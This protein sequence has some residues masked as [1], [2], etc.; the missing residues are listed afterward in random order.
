M[1]RAVKSSRSVRGMGLRALPLVVGMVAMLAAAQCPGART[2]SDAKRPAAARGDSAEQVVYG[3]RMLLTQQNVS[4]G[5]LTATT[6][7]VFAEGTRLELQGVVF[8]FY[9]TAGVK[10]GVL[11]GETGTY[12]TKTGQLNVRGKASV[13]RQ[14]GRRLESE[15]IL[16]DHARS[17]ISADGAFV[18]SDGPG[19]PRVSGTTFES[20]ARLR[21][22]SRRPSTTKSR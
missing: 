9:D 8:T 19:T 11:S 13:V 10:S 16:Y 17:T 20:D 5:L 6:A 3:A 14:D 12:S 15:H 21:R 7:K 22:A 4:K 2:G 1:A 18:Y